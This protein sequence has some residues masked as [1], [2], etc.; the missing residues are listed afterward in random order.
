MFPTRFIRKNFVLIALLLLP[1][2]VLQAQNLVPN[3]S[4]ENYSNCPAAPSE[5]PYPSNPAISLQDWFVP[6]IGTSDYFNTCASW[7]VSVPNNF[8]GYQSPRTGNGYAGTYALLDS[9]SYREYLQAKLLSPLVSGHTYFVSYWVSAIDSY[10]TALIVGIDQLGVLFYPDSIQSSGFNADLIGYT[11]QVTAPTGSPITESIG[12]ANISGSYVAAGDE[13]WMILGNFEPYSA[14]NIATIH[15]GTLF[16]M[17]YYYYDDI[18]VLDL[19]G[20]P[21]AYAVSDTFICPGE[22]LMLRGR[23]GSEAYLWNDGDTSETRLI[24]DTGTYW[25]RSIDKSDCTFAVDTFYVHLKVSDVSLDLGDDT[26]IC[27][28]QPFVLNAYDS[29][30]LGY[31]WNTGSVDSAIRIDAPGLY[32]VSA[33]SACTQASD[34][35]LVGPVPRPEVRLPEDTILCAGTSLLLSLEQP[36]MSCHWN[37]GSDSC[38]IEVVQPGTYILN[39]ENICGEQA[40][41]SVSVSYSGCD[42]CLFVPNAFSPNGDG[43]NDRFAVVNNCLMNTFK[44][45]IY[46]RFGQLIFSCF[47]PGES[48]DGT[49]KGKPADAGVYFYHIEASPKILSL[50]LIKASGDLILIR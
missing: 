19:D 2:L 23:A 1:S 24:A 20:A 30:F 50:P 7:P 40:S 35:I 10:Y 48:W 14:L 32:S 42:H 25:I 47:D 26:V 17:A 15:P 22:E 36:G 16:Q 27:R 34:S 49:Y 33:W 38:C 12:W 43:L 45:Y 37:T 29:R 21:G 46:N 3:P 41:D 31:R 8:I 9:T 39:V 13:R 6:T 11:P 4:F 5:I 28:D 18:C 44:L